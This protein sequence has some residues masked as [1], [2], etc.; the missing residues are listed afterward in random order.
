MHRNLVFQ[1]S[2]YQVLSYLEKLA[3]AKILLNFNSFKTEL[4][5]VSLHIQNGVKNAEHIRRLYIMF[6]E[7]ENVFVF[8]IHY[9]DN[10]RWR[11]ASTL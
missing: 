7:N 10:S 2:I 8:I 5:S 3:R 9:S 1:V 4:S 11:Y 6:C